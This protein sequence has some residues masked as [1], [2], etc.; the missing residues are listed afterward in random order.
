MNQL[1]SARELARMRG[2]VSLALSILLLLNSI[3]STHSGAAAAP[4]ASHFIDPSA[5]VQCGAPYKPC[6]FGSNV[7]VG[8]FAALYAGPSS[9]GST[10][11]ITIG[12]DSDVQD[13]TI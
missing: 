7:Y 12:N 1:K 2:P 9:G 11:F 3:P 13:N 6:S 10:P 5:V 4:A 8:P